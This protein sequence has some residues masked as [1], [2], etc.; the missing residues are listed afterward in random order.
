MR[1]FRCI[2]LTTT[3]LSI[4]CL[5]PVHGGTSPEAACRSVPL[6]LHPGWI[7]SAAFVPA[8]QKILVVDSSLNRLLLVSPDG[9]TTKISGTLADR[10]KL[11]ALVVPAEDGFLLKLVEPTLLVL[12]NDLKLREE[13]KLQR[14]AA[15]KA[16][17]VGSLYQWTVAG[18]AVLAYGSLRSPSLPRGYE[19]GFLRFPASG[20][21]PGR[22]EMLLPFGNG[23]FYVLGYQYLASLGST[24][25]FLAMDRKAVLYKVPPGAAPV[26]RPNAVPTAFRDL[27]KLQAQ[28][29][30]PADAPAL[31]AELEQ[32]TMPAGLYGGADGFLY[33]LTRQPGHVAG[34][35]DWTI[36]RIDAEGNRILGS[37][38][39]HSAAKHLTAV[40]AKDAWYFFERG[41]VAPTGGQS[42]GSMIVVPNARLTQL[43]PS[44]AD[45]CPELGR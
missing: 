44:S 14:S 13:T 36:Y 4:L 10:A 30:G 16:F 31:Y 18:R 21:V 38:H 39:L 8:L 45:L 27:P 23:D 17:T 15:P 11:P 9:E 35:T 12:D 34:M 3:L 41:E 1:S 22:P 26:A 24:G 29:T 2:A 6:S 40:P 19:L 7:S 25:Y 43:G 20:G 33:L 42:I 32:R 28:M 37:G 5:A